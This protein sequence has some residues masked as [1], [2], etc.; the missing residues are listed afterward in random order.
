MV[1]K[2]GGEGGHFYVFS[3]LHASEHSD[4][5]CFFCLEKLITIF[6][7]GGYTPPLFTENSAKMINLIFTPSLRCLLSLLAVIQVLSQTTESEEKAF[8]QDV[9]THRNLDNIFIIVEKGN[10]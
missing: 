8:L 5:L 9:I 2:G 4:F 3:F 1:S 6:M 7:E 10:N